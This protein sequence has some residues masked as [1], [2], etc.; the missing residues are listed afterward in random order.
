MKER[1]RENKYSY[2]LTLIDYNFFTYLW[3]KANSTVCRT[4]HGPFVFIKT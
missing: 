3:S 4:A 1:E 2:L